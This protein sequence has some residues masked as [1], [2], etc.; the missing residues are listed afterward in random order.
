MM[1]V[2]AVLPVP[3]GSDNCPTLAAG[4]ESTL[5]HNAHPSSLPAFS[6]EVQRQVV[7]ASR[8]CQRLQRLVPHDHPAAGHRQPL[9]VDHA[10]IMRVR[11]APAPERPIAAIRSV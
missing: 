5:L 10:Q 8:P 6:F 2:W 3:S 1:P 7:G 11:V 4:P 9:G